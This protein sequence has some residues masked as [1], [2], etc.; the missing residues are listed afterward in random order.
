MYFHHEFGFQVCGVDY[1]E[2]GCKMARDAL[3]REGIRGRVFFDDVFSNSFQKE[4]GGSFDIVVSFGFLEHFYDPRGA[5]AIHLNLVRKGGFV[6]IEVPNYCTRSMYR[7]LLIAAGRE[8]EVVASHNVQLTELSR[9]KRH[10]DQFDLDIRLLDYVGPIDLGAADPRWP[11]YLWPLH[12][13]NQLLGYLTFWLHSEVF[14][15][16]ILLIAKKK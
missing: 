9:L 4:H 10:L 15:P 5:I 2:E 3:A 16:S 14:S 13:Y 1:S 11:K 8:K 12:L 7:R 6:I